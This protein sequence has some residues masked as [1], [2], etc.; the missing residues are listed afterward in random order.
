M[1]NTPAATQATRCHTGRSPR[2]RAVF[3]EA[4]FPDSLADVAEVSRHLTAS[5]FLAAA[6]LFPPSVAVYAAHIKPRFVGEIAATIRGAG[7]P[8]VRVAEPGQTVEVGPG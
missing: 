4:S 6:R 5:Q 1:I 2:L 3:L 7:L 8:N